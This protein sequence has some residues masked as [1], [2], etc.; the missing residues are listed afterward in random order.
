MTYP[1][2]IKIKKLIVI[3]AFEIIPNVLLPTKPNT[4]PI[5]FII[6]VSNHN[7]EDWPN[8]ISGN[9]ANSPKRKQAT[10]KTNQLFF[11]ILL[12]S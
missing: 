2:N 7:L 10:D 11:L 9:H 6:K 3:S 8:K 5:G 12:P 4:N 1:I